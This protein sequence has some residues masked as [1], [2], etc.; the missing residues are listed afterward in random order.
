M[1]DKRPRRRA[2]GDRLHH[3]RLDFQKTAL[4]K[5]LT[6]VG[7]DGR[8]QLERGACR[9]VHD[10]VHITLSVAGFLIGQPVKLFR[11]G[12]QRFSQQ[13][14]RIDFNGQFAGLGFEHHTFGAEN[15]AQI[16]ILERLVATF[17][18]RTFLNKYLYIAGHIA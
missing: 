18:H 15:I 1:G 12:L 3:R 11:Q 2:A 16:P 6:D 8:A 14:Q 4:V 9:L 10:Q 17:R 7:D 5:E 13:A